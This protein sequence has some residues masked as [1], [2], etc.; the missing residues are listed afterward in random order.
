MIKTKSIR[1]PVEPSDGIRILVM[2][3][4]PRRHSQ[5][6]LGLWDRRGWQPNL[7]PSW[8]LLNAWRRRRIKWDEYTARYLKEMR[9]QRLAISTL[10]KTAEARDVTVLCIEAEADRHC[11]RHLLKKLIEQAIEHDE[12]SAESAAEEVKPDRNTCVRL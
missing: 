12:S 2:R 9:S 7:A 3:F 11:H 1:D 4:W 6:N 10:A 5:K 8:E